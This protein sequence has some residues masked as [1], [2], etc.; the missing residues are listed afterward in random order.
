[1][2]LVKGG[3]GAIAAADEVADAVLVSVQVAMGNDGSSP[4]AGV[5][6]RAEILDHSNVSL[7]AAST[8]APVTIPPGQ[9]PGNGTAAAWATVNLTVAKMGLW[10]VDNPRLYH[11]VTRLVAADGGVLDEVSTRFGPRLAEVSPAS[12]LSL[13]G[14]HVKLRG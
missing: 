8:A 5:T 7:V 9:A 3:A 10:S 12:G 4:T 13:N 11:V 6:V 2:S 1:M 14:K